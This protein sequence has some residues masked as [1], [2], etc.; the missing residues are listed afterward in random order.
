MVSLEESKT[1]E[2][3]PKLPDDHASTALIINAVHR[4]N[5]R[6]SFLDLPIKA[7][8]KI[9]DYVAEQKDAAP[10]SYS[11]TV[12][13]RFPVKV[14]YPWRPTYLSFAIACKEIAEAMV[15]RMYPA[16]MM[17]YIDFFASDSA[18]R[19]ADPDPV[20]RLTIAYFP[21][22]L[23]LLKKLQIDLV[24]TPNPSNLDEL[25]TI[26]NEEVLSKLVEY[27]NRCEALER[28][29][30]RFRQWDLWG[31][32]Q[33]E[34]MLRL[35]GSITVKCEIKLYDDPRPQHYKGDTLVQL[36]HESL[37]THFGGDRSEMNS[38]DHTM[39]HS[40]SL[41]PTA[42]THVL[43]QP[44]SAP[45]PRLGFLDL[46]PEIR[47]MIYDLISSSIDIYRYSN[48]RYQWNLMNSYPCDLGWDSRMTTYLSSAMS[49][50]EVSQILVPRLY[51]QLYMRITIVSDEDFDEQIGN[52]YDDLRMLP[53][54]LLLDLLTVL[55]I[56]T[57]P[58]KH[59]SRDLEDLL[60]YAKCFRGLRTFEIN[61]VE[62]WTRI[63]T[64][65]I[66]EMWP[67]IT[68]KCGISLTWDENCLFPLDHIEKLIGE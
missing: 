17:L 46:P 64:H 23:D 25:I 26:P 51:A 42:I 48:R 30:M 35:W 67:S 15:P 60:A 21:L 52:Q 39:T 27:I 65:Q 9:Y 49:C 2:L 47:I 8:T 28:F 44:D 24:C 34:T 13:G 7:R 56:Q 62:G 38:T 61:F 11:C 50:R 20:E 41:E 40:P 1:Y 43:A 5:K 66:L 3:Q 45:A 37:M 31:K 14:W 22:R 29:L 19:L 16:G 12:M 63:R 6:L 32:E 53:F 57:S 33:L 18:R 58:T 10:G 36:S 4:I 54:P 68:I 55:E 59:T